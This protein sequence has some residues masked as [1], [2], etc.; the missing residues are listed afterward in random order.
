MRVVFSDRAFTA[1]MAETAEKIETETGGLF[2]GTIDDDTWYVIEAIDPGPKSIFE[3]SYFEYD[4]KYT[5]HLINKIANLYEEKL[6]LIGL[7]HRHPGSFDVFSTT[8]NDT[9]AKYAEMR[10]Y[11][12]IS[13]L[14]NIDPK[15]RITMYHVG[16]PYKYTKISYVV[17]NDL[18]PEKYMKLKTPQQYEQ[19]MQNIL[20]P[21]FI[22][23]ELHPS[24]S[25]KSFVEIIKPFFED[26]AVSGKVERLK[27]SSEELKN[28][29][30]D[31]TVSDISFMSDQIKIEM[32]VVQKE[33]LLV[34]VQESVD[35][36]VKVFFAYSEK[37]DSLIFQYNGKNYVYEDGLFENLYYMA[38]NERERQTNVAVQGIVESEARKI[39][40]GVL[41]LIRFDRNGDE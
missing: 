27:L 21:K 16:R 25:L 7:W 22:K 18:V 39:I 30:I 40:D 10:E 17:G 9:N 5:Q 12:A 3:V 8:D 13:A 29:L 23:D 26:R 6:Q 15:F 37:R 24:I 2:L 36:V 32:S 14:V 41:R 38:T 19:I 35:G 4:Q 33:G 31:N 11:G 1:V 34:L 20:N 28:K